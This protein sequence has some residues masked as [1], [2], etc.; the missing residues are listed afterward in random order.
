MPNGGWT[1]KNDMVLIY[2]EILFS[3]EKRNY[4]PICDNM[5]QPWKYYAKEDNLKKDK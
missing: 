3:R 2:N 4:S 5:D 1:D